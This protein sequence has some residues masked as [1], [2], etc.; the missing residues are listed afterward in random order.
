MCFLNLQKNKIRN[1]ILKY[2]YVFLKLIEL[3]ELFVLIF[4]VSSQQDVVSGHKNG[5]NAIYFMFCV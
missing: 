2:K 5:L 4:A 1:Q 3:D